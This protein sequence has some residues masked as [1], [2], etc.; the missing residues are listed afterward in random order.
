M[1]GRLVAHYDGWRALGRSGRE[2]LR[3]LTEHAF[4]VP[5]RVE[6]T[7]RPIAML[8]LGF[9]AHNRFVGFDE[10]GGLR[11]LAPWFMKTPAQAGRRHDPPD[12]GP[13]GS[14]AWMRIELVLDPRGARLLVNGALRH[15][16]EGNFSSFR[17]RVAV[18]LAEAGVITLRKFSIAPP[19]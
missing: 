18:G 10:S 6:L 2:P 11:D 8:K 1:S 16:W 17:G 12:A 9:G 5:F 15:T 13:A 4:G 19:V 14:D 3:E 7:A